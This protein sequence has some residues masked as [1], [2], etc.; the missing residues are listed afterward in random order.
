MTTTDH[1]LDWA[2]MIGAGID[3][4]RV[5]RVTDQ[6]RPDLKQYEAV[7]RDGATKI[8]F[9]AYFDI[10]E[11]GF[12]S[13]VYEQV[14]TQDEPRWECGTPDWYATSAECLAAVKAWMDA[15]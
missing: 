1:M 2:A 15:N 5:N 4:V 9:G 11:G 8:M 12:D 7:A 3:I 10:S 6:Q 13:A 14:G